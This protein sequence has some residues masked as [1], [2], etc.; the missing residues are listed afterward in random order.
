[1]PELGEHPDFATNAQRVKNRTALNARLE[2][3]LAERSTAEWE[4]IL[5]DAGVP[6]SR[7][8]TIEDVLRDPQTAE[9]DMIMELEH[10]SLGTIKVPGIPIKLSETPCS[11]RRPPPLLGQHQEEVLSEAGLPRE[12]IAALRL[13]KQAS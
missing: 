7:I 6:C 12:T 13:E 8:N 5:T 11:G 9:R 1:L 4:R 10:A 3:R 2:S